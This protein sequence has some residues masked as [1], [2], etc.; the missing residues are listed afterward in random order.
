MNRLE[1]ILIAFFGVALLVSLGFVANS[2]AEDPNPDK[3]ITEVPSTDVVHNTAI[4][5][6]ADLVNTPLGIGTGI[7]GVTNFRNIGDS[8]TWEYYRFCGNQGDVV[9]IEVH[10]TTS[11]MDPAMQTCQGTTADSTGIFAFSGCGPSMGPFI[12]AADDNNGIP[13][14]VG[15]IFADPKNVFVLPA[16]GEYTLMVFDFIPASPPPPFI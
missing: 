13:H 5:Y 16:T 6:N 4:T 11:A 15:G 1:K 2:T 12:G 7:P 10:R 9:E 3:P 8:S 14:G